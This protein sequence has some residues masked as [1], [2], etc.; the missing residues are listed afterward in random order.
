MAG[1]FKH[2]VKIVDGKIVERKPNT[3]LLDNLG[4]ASEAIEEMIDMIDFLSS[5]SLELLYIAH[6]NY[7]SKHN[8]SYK[9]EG[10]DKWLE[11]MKE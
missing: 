6:R 1:S 3:E 7:I 4:D 11:S 2:C 10:F 5:G 9:P 8:P